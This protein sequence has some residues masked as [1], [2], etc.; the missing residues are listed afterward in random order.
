MFLGR[1]IRTLP[2][3]AR[4]TVPQANVVAGRQEA[5]TAGR[6]DLLIDKLQELP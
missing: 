6:I 1:V 5:K 3:A 2:L 4:E